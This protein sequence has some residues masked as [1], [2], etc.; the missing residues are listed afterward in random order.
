MP[1]IALSDPWPIRSDGRSLCQLNR[2]EPSA[3][4]SAKGVALQPTFPQI[5]TRLRQNDKGSEGANLL[6]CSDHLSPP[7]VPHGICERIVFVI[8]DVSATESIVG[9]E[10]VGHR[11]FDAK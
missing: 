10:Q 5:V 6:T 2:R 3:A 4:H 9:S 7:E 11:G 8:G 1:E